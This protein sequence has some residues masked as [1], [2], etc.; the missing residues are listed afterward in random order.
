MEMTHEEIKDILHNIKG[1]KNIR[2]YRSISGTDFF[3]FQANKI[4]LKTVAK[5]A[6]RFNNRI[7]VYLDGWDKI[8]YLLEV[9]HPWLKA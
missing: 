9:L 3:Y 8:T 1:Y 2:H 7:S 4:A 5:L 6:A